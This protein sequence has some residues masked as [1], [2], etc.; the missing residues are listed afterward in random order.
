MHLATQ[1]I[2]QILIGLL[3]GWMLISLRKFEGS[4]G[5]NSSCMITRLGSFPTHSSFD[6]L[7]LVLNVKGRR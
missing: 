4:S 1:G 5:G 6:F 3:F 7:C 2:L